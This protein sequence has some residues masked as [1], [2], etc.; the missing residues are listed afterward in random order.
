M[1][2]GITALQSTFDDVTYLELYCYSLLREIDH[3]MEQYTGVEK[4]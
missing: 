2:D 4:S 3:H 1:I